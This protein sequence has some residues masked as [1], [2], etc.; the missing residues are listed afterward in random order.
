[1]I[2]RICPKCR[3][4]MNGD[5]CIKPNCGCATKMSST[6]YWCDDCN[7][8]I[9]ENICPSCGNKGRYIAT[10]M[11]PVFPEENVLISLILGD[12][13]QK[14]QESSVWFGSGMYIIDGKKVRLSITK[15]NSLPLD[16]I[17]K[18][19][20][21]YEAFVTKINYCFFD[22]YIRKFIKA[23]ADRYNFITEEAVQFV[24][25]YREKYAIED[26]MVSFSGGKDSTVTSHIVNRALG[27]KIVIY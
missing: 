19:K 23:N 27:I 9:F 14:Y 7:V 16:K 8:P 18:L 26:M 10:D 22:E 6:I 12:N 13:P 15:L 20:E 25:K 11:R 3:V 5:K 1:M 17:H 4:P 21:K 2:E 24:Q